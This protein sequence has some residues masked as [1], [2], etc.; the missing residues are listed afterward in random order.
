MFCLVIRNCLAL[1]Q[2]LNFLV[3]YDSFMF[4]RSTSSCSKTPHVYQR[5]KWIIQKPHKVNKKGSPLCRLTTKFLMPYKYW[6][7]VFIQIND[8]S[9]SSLLS[10]LVLSTLSPFFVYPNCIKLSFPL[11]AMLSLFNLNPND[12]FIT[13]WVHFFKRN[14][15]REFGKK[16]GKWPF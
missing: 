8:F 6:G 15:D 11:S 2:A 9:Y 1:W 4:V 7:S 3:H 16:F 5:G 13:T 10:F 14:V 12:A